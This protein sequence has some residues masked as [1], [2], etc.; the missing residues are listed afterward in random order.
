MKKRVG[1]DLGGTTAK[2]GVVNENNE[3][4]SLLSVV[5]FDAFYEGNVVKYG[6]IAGVSTLPQYRKKGNIRKYKY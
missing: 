3:I 4:E 6:G 5:S 1:V 2:L